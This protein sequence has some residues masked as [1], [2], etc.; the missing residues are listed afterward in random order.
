LRSDLHITLFSDIA[1]QVRS[2]GNVNDEARRRDT[3]KALGGTF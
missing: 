1:C 2:S 3:S